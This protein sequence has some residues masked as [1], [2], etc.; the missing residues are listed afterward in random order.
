M[1]RLLNAL[2]AFFFLLPSALLAAPPAAAAEPD[3]LAEARRL[4]AELAIGDLQ[5]DLA[6]QQLSQAGK[7][8]PEMAPLTEWLAG[9]L[10]GAEAARRIA[11]VYAEYLTAAQCRELRLFFTIPPGQ[12]FWQAQQER[13]RGGK[14][15]LFLRPSPEDAR[16]IEGFTKN[17]SAWQALVRVRPQ[18]DAGVAKV[19]EGWVRQLV[20]AQ[21][22]GTGE[23]GQAELLPG[24]GALYRD[25][26][27]R[28]AQLQA[29]TAERLR[30]LDLAP[31]LHPATL[32]S[33]E[34]IRAGR[35]KVHQA[36]RLLSESQHDMNELNEALVDGLRRLPGPAVL[37]DSLL[38]GSERQATATYERMLR[39]EEN[40]RRLMTLM[41]EILAL[42]ETSRERLHFVDGK[43][44]F[45][46]VDELRQY[47][48]L[49]AR[50]RREADT[51]ARL[52]AE[53]K[54]L[55]EAVGSAR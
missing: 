37:R 26:T 20:Q 13:A 40:Q 55:R 50:L 48:A 14:R 6:Y 25:I 18:I 21:V 5:A 10:N 46:D 15:P 2:A 32:V 12:A 24:L 29:R 44:V 42:A 27:T 4:V 39:Y 28:R 34:G 7:S 52:Q 8:Q 51:E 30:A 38:Q 47:D 16:T 11:P 54:A 33:A 3:S 41:R 31:V 9:Q 35:D 17:S 45:D 36:E 53:E 23:P 22:S 43:L 19:M 49:L 1:S